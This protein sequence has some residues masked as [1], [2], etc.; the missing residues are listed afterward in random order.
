MFL[1]ID[2]SIYIQSF[3]D[4]VLAEEAISRRFENLRET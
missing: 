1:S 3:I 2:E 4:Q